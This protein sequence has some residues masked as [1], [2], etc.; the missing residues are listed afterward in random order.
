MM[1][2]FLA[3]AADRRRVAKEQGI[4]DLKDLFNDLKI[5]LE[6]TFTFTAEQKV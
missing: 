4:G 2:I 5:R 1:A 6:D 3:D